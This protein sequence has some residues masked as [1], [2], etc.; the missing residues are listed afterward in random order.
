MQ[1]C[2]L[3]AKLVV[4]ID[5]NLVTKC[6]GHYRKWPGIVDPND[7]SCIYTIGICSNP[8]DIEIVS[9][10]LCTNDLCQKNKQKR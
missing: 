4:D 6:C 8:C 7:G 3:I 5:N 10:C 2:T 9:D 1:R